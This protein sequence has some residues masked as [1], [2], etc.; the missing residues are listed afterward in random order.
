[1]RVWVDTN[2]NT[3]FIVSLPRI[4]PV[5]E[6]R[7]NVKFSSRFLFLCLC[8]DDTQFIIDIRKATKQLVIKW[9]SSIEYGRELWSTDADGKFLWNW[10]SRLYGT[11]VLLVPQP[12]SD[13]CW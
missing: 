3:H 10:S 13:S 1:V 9:M 7:G 2:V 12:H 8:R 4:S 6:L 11:L 5:A